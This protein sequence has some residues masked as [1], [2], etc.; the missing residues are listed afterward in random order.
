[1]CGQNDRVIVI[2][3]ENIGHTDN[4]A[5]LGW[6]T[7]TTSAAGRRIQHNCGTYLEILKLLPARI[8]ARC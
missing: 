6:S 5:G 2:V 7:I 4:W 3:S 1:M 8:I